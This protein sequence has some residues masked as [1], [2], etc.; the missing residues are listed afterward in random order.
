[1]FFFLQQLNQLGEDPLGSNK[2]SNLLLGPSM[3]RLLEQAQQKAE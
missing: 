1:M 3:A 2:E